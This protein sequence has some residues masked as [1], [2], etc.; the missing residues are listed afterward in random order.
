MMMKRATAG[1]TH[2][3]SRRQK[4]FLTAP[5]NGGEKGRRAWSRFYITTSAR[6]TKLPKSG[7]KNGYGD[8]ERIENGEPTEKVQD[9]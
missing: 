6:I 9:Q 3:P 2:D 1:G 7:D 5:E 8:Y 4:T